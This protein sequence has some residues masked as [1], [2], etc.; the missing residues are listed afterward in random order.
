MALTDIL[1]KAVTAT[2]NNEAGY[3]SEGNPVLGIV[4]KIEKAGNTA[5]YPLGYD[6]IQ[7]GGTFMLNSTTLTALDASTTDDYVITVGFAEM[8]ENVPITS[9]A[10]KK[11]AVG[12]VVAVDGSGALVKYV[13][14]T[15]NTTAAVQALTAFATSVDTTANTATIRVL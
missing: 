15:V 3:G 6:G 12:N 13:A 7:H 5:V 4:K 14:A 9:T 10:S 2:G 1:G 11:P 8:F